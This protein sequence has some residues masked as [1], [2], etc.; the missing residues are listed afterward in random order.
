MSTME[1][2]H[3]SEESHTEVPR[4]T[5]V[6]ALKTQSDFFSTQQLEGNDLYHETLMTF[7]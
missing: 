6:S 5:L 2:K 7:S 4:T 1:H 3:G